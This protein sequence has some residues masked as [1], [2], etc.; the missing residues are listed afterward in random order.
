MN[1]NSDDL[2][3]SVG[4]YEVWH[5]WQK[6]QFGDGCLSALSGELAR[7]GVSRVFLVTTRSL[8][9][10]A[11]LLT[12]VRSAIGSAL[13]G[14]FNESDQHVP[15]T[16][17]LAAGTSARRLNPDCIVSFGGSSVIDTAKGVALV[18]SEEIVDDAGF[19]PYKVIFDYPESVTMPRLTRNP[20]PHVALPTTLS[21]GEYTGVIGITDVATRRKDLFSDDRLSP[22]TILLDPQLTNATPRRLWAASGVKTMSDAIEQIYSTKGHPM[23]EALCVRAIEW[24][25][26]YLP[27]A[28]STDPE[29]R[30]D[31]RLRCQIASWMAIAG[32]NNAGTVGGIG[33]SLRHQLGPMYGIPHGEAMGVVLPHVIEFNA[34]AIR[35]DYA[36][37]A[38][39]LGVNGGSGSQRTAAIIQAITAFI[40]SLGL[41]DRLELLGVNRTDLPTV[42]KHVM[43]DFA[44]LTNPRLVENEAQVIGI[45][46]RAM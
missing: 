4:T 10:E 22:T 30:R 28:D 31:A 13:V 46:E 24:F 12:L 33:A 42:A 41:P 17:V 35:D 2:P 44:T 8:K 37:L 45:L 25:H 9:R 15:R 29:I 40:A 20:I 32:A 7:L 11:A 6:V 14:E 3:V 27:V 39:A 21:G 1:R 36:L 23:V 43:Q 18:L 5:Q 26:R 38:R 19:E 16:T 34:K